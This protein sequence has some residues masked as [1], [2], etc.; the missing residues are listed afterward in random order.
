VN[1]LVHVGVL[2][3]DRWA[4]IAGWTDVFKVDKAKPGVLVEITEVS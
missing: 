3:G 4:N 2:A 1:A